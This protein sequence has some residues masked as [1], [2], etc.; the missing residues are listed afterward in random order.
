MGTSEHRHGNG[1]GAGGSLL[2]T[3]LEY[4]SH[5]AGIV[6]EVVNEQ[7]QP[8]L[9]RAADVGPWAAGQRF[10][11]HLVRSLNCPVLSPLGSQ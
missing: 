2:K 7:L 8:K 9:A 5:Q 6:F 4:K 1:H 3:M 11:V 10:L